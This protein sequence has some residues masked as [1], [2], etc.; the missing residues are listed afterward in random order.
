MAVCLGYFIVAFTRI[1]KSGLDTIKNFIA[2]K[3]NLLLIGVEIT[4]T[5]LNERI[6][7][8]FNIEHAVGKL[9]C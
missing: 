8:L 2:M 5:R 9:N 7:K 4:I 1:R 6:V 3:F